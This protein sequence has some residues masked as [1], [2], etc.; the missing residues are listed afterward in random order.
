MSAQ[1]HI[2]RA[3]VGCGGPRLQIGVQSRLPR[4]SAYAARIYRSG[5]SVDGH[6]PPRR[7]L[8]KQTPDSTQVSIVLALYSHRSVIALVVCRDCTAIALALE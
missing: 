3:L 1:L 7:R 2:K 8:Q 4:A 6:A 5:R